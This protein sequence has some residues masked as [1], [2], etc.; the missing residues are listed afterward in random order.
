MKMINVTLK[1]IRDIITSQFITTEHTAD[2]NN[3]DA[4]KMRNNFW[5]TIKLFVFFQY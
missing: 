2:K 3:I 4:P 5:S 1:T